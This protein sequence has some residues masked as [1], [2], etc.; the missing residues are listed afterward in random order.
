MAAP[1]HTPVLLEEVLHM[2]AI[3]PGMRVIDA[4]IDGGGHAAAILQRIGPTGR[5]LGLDRDPEVAVRAR[6][7]FAAEI[8]AGQAVIVHSSFRRLAEVAVE[9]GFAEVDGI[10]FDLGLSSFHL[11]QGGRGFSFM[12]D[13]PLDLRFDPSEEGG[14]T[15]ADVLATRDAAELTALFRDWGEERFASRIARAVVA[16]R[17]RAPIATSRELFELIRPVLPGG[18]RQ[19]AARSAARIFQAL[20][21]A[22]NDEL[23]AVAQ[24]LPRALDLLAP[25]GRLAV[26]S[27]HS[28]EDRLVK[29]AFTQARRENRVEVLTKRPIRPSDAEI[30]AN[31]RAASAKLRT[32]ERRRAGEVDEAAI[33][34]VLRYWLGEDESR[35]GCEDRKRVWFE[36]SDAT[37][38]YVRQ[39]F[40]ELAERAARGELEGWARTPRGRLALVIVLDQFPRNLHRGEARA[41]ACDEAALRL[42]LEG[43]ERGDDAAYSP[44]ERAIFAMPLQHAEDLALQEKGVRY[45]EELARQVSDDVRPVFEEFRDFARRHR[46]AIARFGR[47][48]HRNALLG[49]SSTTAEEEFLR[50]AKGFL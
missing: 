30:A 45:F 39:R 44:L 23:G 40:G 41:F 31:S 36:K 18:E 15:A 19:H 13:E 22:V 6:E 49:R 5:L 50:A 7:R 32:A 24:A 43:L 9:H 14:E 4:T 34:R 25:G 12:R 10:L 2:L 16:A 28:L 29:Q 20:R 46:D 48:P 47:F 27:F 3:R 11:D 1:I 35:E 17:Q 33:A 21:I 37:D 38:N 8:A 26:I 42:C